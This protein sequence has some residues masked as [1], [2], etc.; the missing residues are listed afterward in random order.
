MSKYT[1]LVLRIL[2]TSA[3]LI[4]GLT[5]TFGTGFAQEGDDFLVITV[6]PI[7]NCGEVQFTI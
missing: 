6:D 4:A 3:I 5:S 7:P 2:I 1:N